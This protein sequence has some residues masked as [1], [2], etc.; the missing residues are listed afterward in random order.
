MLLPAMLF[1]GRVS[2]VRA[3]GPA[4]A[5]PAPAPVPM[6]APQPLPNR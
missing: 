4:M 3:V 2:T 6:P 1:G 5:A